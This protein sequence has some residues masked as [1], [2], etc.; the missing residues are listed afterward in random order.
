[1]IFFLLF[2]LMCG[3]RWRQ[4]HW[5]LRFMDF[6]F[7]ALIGWRHIFRRC[8]VD[9]HIRPRPLFLHPHCNTNMVPVRNQLLFQDFVDIFFLLPI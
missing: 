3:D 5:N 6:Y 4:K 7:W 9:T 2:G 1:L 8:C